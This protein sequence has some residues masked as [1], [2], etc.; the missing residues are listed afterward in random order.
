MTATGTN[1]LEASGTLS[2]HP[3]AELLVEISQAMLDGSL[4]LAREGRKA[5]LY[6]RSGRVVHAASNSKAHRLFHLLLQ[7]QLIAA[8]QVSKFPNFAN[9]VEFARHLLASGAVSQGTIDD[10][11]REQVRL[12]LEDALAW[13]DGEW[14]FS[15]LV[16]AKDDISCDIDVAAMLFHHARGVAR[17]RLL[18]NFTSHEDSFALAP[19]PDDLPPLQMHESFVLAHFGSDPLT[20]ADLHTMCQMPDEGLMQA[21]YT[22]WLGGLIVRRSWASPAFPPDLIDAIIGAKVEKTRRPEPS[23]VRLPE[24][25][26]A[27]PEPEADDSAPQPEEAKPADAPAMTLD[28]YLDQVENGIGFYGVLGID[29]TADNAE[30]KGAYFA[31]AKLFHPDRFHREPAGKLK[32]IQSAFTA[33][34][35]AYEVLRSPE[36]R[37]SYNEKYRAEVAGRAKRVAEG[38][39]ETVTDPNE[40]NAELGLENFEEGMRY[41]NAEEYEQAAACFGRAVVYSPNNAVF[42]AHLGKALSFTDDKY[43]HKAEQAMQTAV[44]LDPTD[45]K[46]RMIL[47]DFYVDYNMTKRAEGELTRYLSLVPDDKE[48]QRM[49]EKIKGT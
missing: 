33:V 39:T 18:A 3:V 30:V 43:R 15:P 34:A 14:T 22:L 38:K 21:L 29:D 24:R 36:S 17:Q 27:A 1:Q 42:Q 40:R 44:R 7:K 25:P 35:R 2:G 13:P 28:E 9:D 49:L 4:R 19:P 16:R 46:L 37:A 10:A 8:A 23:A 45:F 20:L 11:T 26:A 31:L 48:A 5:I 12:V 47:V 41:L 6:F 32:R